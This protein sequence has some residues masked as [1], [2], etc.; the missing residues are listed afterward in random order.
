ME[1]PQE[2]KCY[3][4]FYFDTLAGGEA[5]MEVAWNDTAFKE[6]LIR[7]GLTGKGEFIIKREELETLLLALTKDPSRYVRSTTRVAGIKYV[8][9]PQRL[10]QD[11]LEYKK[12]KN[13]NV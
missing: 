13:K 3:D 12:Y 7:I 8:P 9:V 1:E 5:W 6:Q 4:R 2:K 10:Y 11:Y